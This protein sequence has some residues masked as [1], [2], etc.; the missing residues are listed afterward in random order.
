MCVAVRQ[1]LDAGFTHDIVV[2]LDV[3]LAALKGHPS[4]VVSINPE[5]LLRNH[6]FL[7]SRVAGNQSIEVLE[8]GLVIGIGDPDDLVKPSSII[9]HV[10]L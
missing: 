8:I 7:E 10:A 2:N 9:H 6:D 5:L 4:F 1:S 3:V